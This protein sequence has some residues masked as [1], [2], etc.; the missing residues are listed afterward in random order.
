MDEHARG[1]CNCG[2]IRVA[3]AKLAELQM[4]WQTLHQLLKGEEK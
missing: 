1:K 3:N 4:C 2:K